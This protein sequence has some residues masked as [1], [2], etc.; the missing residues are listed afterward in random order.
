MR[1]RQGGRS[2]ILA[3]ILQRS[4]KEWAGGKA[5]AVARL[6]YLGQNHAGLGVFLGRRPPKTTMA[7]GL[8]PSPAGVGLAHHGETTKCHR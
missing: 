2:G 3:N 6:E 8:L 5:A 4:N 7:L 1:L